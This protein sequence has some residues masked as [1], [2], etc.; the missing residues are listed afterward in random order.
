MI[1]HSC[2]IPV[3]CSSCLLSCI[4][5]TFPFCIISK[6]HRVYLFFSLVTWTYWVCKRNPWRICTPAFHYTVSCTCL[7]TNFWR[8]LGS[9]WCSKPIVWTWTTII[10]NIIWSS[11]S[12]IIFICYCYIRIRLAVTWPINIYYNLSIY[13]NTIM[14]SNRSCIIRRF[15]SICI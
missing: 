14:Y 10:S 4:I 13:I 3:E 8:F 6:T 2:H 11:K 12:T 9:Y 7:Q 15:P 5:I 1:K